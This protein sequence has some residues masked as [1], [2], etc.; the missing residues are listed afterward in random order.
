[1]SEQTLAIGDRVVDVAEEI[2]CPPA[3][4]AL[5]W[6][7]QQGV[8]AVLGGRNRAQIAGN[9][10]SLDVT[11]TDDQMARL[12]AA[13]AIVHGYPTDFLARDGVRGSV[14]GGMRDRIDDPRLA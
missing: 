8:I 4:V 14:Y 6:V 2:G 11:L 1:M 3:Q 10:A 12:D 7:R 9:I 5:A 13:T